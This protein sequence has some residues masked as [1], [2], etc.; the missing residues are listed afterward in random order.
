[1]NGARQGQ[2]RREG[3]GDGAAQDVIR[4]EAATQGGAGG[5]LYTRRG[6]RCHI[7]A[8]TSKREKHNL[9]DASCIPQGGKDE[10][11]QVV[12]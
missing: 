2:E 6:V 9:C 11:M 1:M 3:G 5:V 10:T 4:D 12:A 7:E 8:E